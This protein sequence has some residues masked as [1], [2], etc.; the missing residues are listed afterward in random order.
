M[1]KLFHIAALVVLLGTLGVW[2]STGAARGWTK[3][4]VSVME[5]EPVTGIEFP[6]EKKQ[7]IMGVELLGAG[8]ALSLMLLGISFVFKSKPKQ[9]TQAV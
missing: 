7:F 2:L 4:S 3:T 1:K 8:V 9:T 6:V 5:V